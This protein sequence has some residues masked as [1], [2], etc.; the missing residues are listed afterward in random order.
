MIL[1]IEKLNL[2]SNPKWI[3]YE[4]YVIYLK[5][6]IKKNNEDYLNRLIEIEN[7]E[8]FNDIKSKNNIIAD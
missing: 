4:Q 1:I 5:E 8:N 2:N 3:I 7:K 6:I